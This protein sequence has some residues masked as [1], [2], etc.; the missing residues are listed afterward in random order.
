[1]TE[2]TALI[3]GYND[4]TF[5]IVKNISLHYENIQIF[6]LDE[7]EKII[8]NS[9]Y[10]ISQFD[11]SD[12]WD[13]LRESVDI[14]RCVAF[15]ILENMAENIFLTIS[16][17][18][19]FKDLTIVALAKDKE[20]EEKL[21]LAGASRILPT[22]QTTANIIVEM[23]EKPIVSEVLHNILYEKSDLKIAQIRVDNSEFFNKE[24][25]A[26]IDWGKEYGVIVLSVLSE[27]MAM[28][29]IYSSKAKHHQIKEGDIFVV[30]GYEQDIKN[31]E[32][33]IG[34]QI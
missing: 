1:M 12:N 4:Y 28:E 15:C 5:E 14:K 11:L 24:Y 29:F 19:T 34:G 9:K 17:R 21:L 13:D 22:I 31:F 7:N 33:I 32:N 6:K 27:E 23:L 2:K 26:D 18:D 10:K 8:Q 16:L 3:F 30:V 25:P 20:S